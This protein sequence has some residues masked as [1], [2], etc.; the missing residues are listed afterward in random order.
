M[1][2]ARGAQQRPATSLHQNVFPAYLVAAFRETRRSMLPSWEHFLK[3]AR[4]PARPVDGFFRPDRFTALRVQLAVADVFGSEI[5][6]IELFRIQAFHTHAL[7]T[8]DL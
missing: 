7:H 1:L 5:L 6:T 3:Q 4:Q 2:M 8:G